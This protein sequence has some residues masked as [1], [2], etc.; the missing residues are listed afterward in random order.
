MLKKGLITQKNQIILYLHNIIAIT[1]PEN[2]QRKMLNLL[3]QKINAG[4]KLHEFSLP[5][6][7]LDLMGMKQYACSESFTCINVYPLRKCF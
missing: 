2:P 5:I 6:M 7:L 3:Q 1:P 4:N